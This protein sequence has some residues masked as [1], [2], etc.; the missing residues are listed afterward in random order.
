MAEE[1]RTRRTPRQRGMARAA[2]VGA[3]VLAGLALTACSG[4]DMPGSASV[5][6]NTNSSESTVWLCKPSEADDPCAGDVSV[7]SVSATGATSPEP[8]SPASKSKFDCFY[9]YPTASPQ[10]TPNANLKVQPEEVDA[11]LSQA[12]QFSRLPGP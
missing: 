3:A 10:R 6:P 4:S 5:H 2:A 12:A 11:A 8:K 1:V 9:V 7:T